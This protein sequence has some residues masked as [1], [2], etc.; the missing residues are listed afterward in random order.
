MSKSLEFGGNNT[1]ATGTATTTEA[2]GTIT[3][4]EDSTVS[5]TEIMKG[6]TPDVRTGVSMNAGQ[7]FY[8]T[9]T[10]VSATGYVVLGE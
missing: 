9:F 3:A 5:F 6:G 10:L 7:V 8:G 4:R 2:F 1:L